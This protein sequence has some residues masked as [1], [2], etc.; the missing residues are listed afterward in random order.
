MKLIYLH[1]TILL[2]LLFAPQVVFAQSDI[3][4]GG[5]VDRENPTVL[6]TQPTD[7]ASISG[8]Q[9]LVA[10]ATDDS[11][12]IRV[13][14]IVASNIVSTDTTSPYSFSLDTTTLSN[15]IHTITARAV[16]T[17]NN[18]ATDTITITVNNPSTTLESPTSKIISPAV[19]PPRVATTPVKTEEKRT[20]LVQLPEEEGII[21]FIQRQ[22]NFLLGLI[23]ATE[24][25]VIIYLIYLL[26]RKRKK[27]E[28]SNP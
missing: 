14:F 19:G 1:A 20:T 5:T 24:I 18:T 10:T 8:S 9:T 4:V 13:E 25:F 26:R 2:S 23:V 22:R 16:D 17:I 12:I 15:G 7:G 27:Q 21:P 3:D 11:G 6:I 28:L